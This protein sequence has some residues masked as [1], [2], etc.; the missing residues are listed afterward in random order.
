MTRNLKNQLFEIAV[1]KNYCDIYSSYEITE[2]AINQV[3]Q[4]LWEIFPKRK[5][6]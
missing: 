5:K 2:N 1:I 6:Q 3:L 4:D